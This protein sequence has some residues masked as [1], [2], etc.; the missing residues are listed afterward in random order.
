M[1]PSITITNPKRKVINE[2]TVAKPGSEIFPVIPPMSMSIPYPKLKNETHIP[3]NDMK[4]IGTTE[5]PKNESR[6]NFHFFENVHPL[7]PLERSLLS[8]SITYGLNP[9]LAARI[10]P[11]PVIRPGAVGRPSRL[12]RA[13]RGLFNGGNWILREDDEAEKVGSTGSARGFGAPPVIG[14]QCWGKV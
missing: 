5:N 13:G 12:P 3:M 2:V 1:T 11:A 14:D 6:N 7:F 4:R 10:A 9:S 8:Y